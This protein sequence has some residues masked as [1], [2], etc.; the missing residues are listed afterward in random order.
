[1]G[2]REVWL[3]S[4]LLLHDLGPELADNAPEGLGTA[5]E[6]KTPPLWGVGQTNKPLLHD[7]RAGRDFDKA[8]RLHGGEAN[9]S[10][11]LYEQLSKQDRQALIEF[12]KSL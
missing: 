2:D 3:Y 10:K 1:M 6:W 4:D 11:A 12:L 9:T 7:G 8:I 5:T